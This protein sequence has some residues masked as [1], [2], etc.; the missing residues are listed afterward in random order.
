M[1]SLHRGN[2]RQTNSNINKQALRGQ[3]E[4][5]AFRP[6]TGMVKQKDMILAAIIALG[7]GLVIIAKSVKS[8]TA[9]VCFLWLIGIMSVLMAIGFFSTAGGIVLT[10]L[11]SLAIIILD[12][13][14]ILA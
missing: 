1:Y 5:T 7:V 14:G 3:A 6:R 11:I 2:T 13:A 8:R 4:R 10:A 9:F 12:D